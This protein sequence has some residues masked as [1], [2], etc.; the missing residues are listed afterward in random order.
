MRLV[1]SGMRR[2][3]LRSPASTCATG[4]RAASPRRASPPAS[5]SCRRRSARCPGGVPGSPPRVSRACGRL[6]AVRTRADAEVDVR[7]RN[8]EL[9]E[10]DVGHRRVVV[11]A[12]V[13]DQVLDARRAH[14]RP[15]SRGRPARASRTAGAR[16]R[17]AIRR[18]VAARESSEPAEH[19]VLRAGTA[20]CRRRSAARARRRRRRPSVETYPAIADPAL[21][22]RRVAVDDRI[23]RRRRASRRRRR[24]RSNSRRA[25]RRRR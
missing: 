20:G 25:S 16:R 8:A 7:A 21:H 12:G 14:S 18:T 23:G 19:A 11:L 15:R 10:E 6:A 3:K 22:A 17:H 24:R 5:S 4:T 9:L 2:L 13:D 1:S